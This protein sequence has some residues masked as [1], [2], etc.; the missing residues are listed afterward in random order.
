M[1]KISN[2]TLYPNDVVFTG[3]EILIGT[4]SDGRTATYLLSA[5]QSYFGGSLDAASVKSLYE[6]NS[7]TNAF[8]DAEK[9]KLAGL[10]GTTT[11]D[12][13]V[14]VDANAKFIFGDPDIAELFTDQTDM[15]MNL[16][17]TTGGNFLFQ[18][19]G[20]DIVTISRS[21][22]NISTIGTLS[23]DGNIIQVKGA[24]PRVQYVETDNGD[25]TWFAIIDGGN[26]SIRE[27]SVSSTR[28]RIN[29]TSGAEFFGGGLKVN[30]ATNN[31]FAIWAESNGSNESGIFFEASSNGELIL[32]DATGN[33]DVH[34]KT[35]GTSTFANPVTVTGTMTATTFSGSASSLTGL[36]ISG[37]DA[38]GTPGSTTFL[39]GDG[40]WAV[41]PGTSGG[42]ASTIINSY[43][44]ETPTGTQ[45]GVNT[46]FTLP[47]G[48]YESG[49]LVV[50]VN[51]SPVTVGS[52]LS[53]TTPGSG[54]F[55]LSVA[56]LADDSLYATFN[57]QSTGATPVVIEGVTGTKDG[58]NTSFTVNS[59]EYTAGS[60]IIIMNGQ[61]LQD[62]AGL[63]ENTPGSGTF[64]LD[65]APQSTDVILAIHK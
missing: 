58:S 59:A 50:Y 29:A 22:G 24:S 25:K 40:S 16:V 55:D 64:T 39:R 44:G 63:T 43:T 42:G 15:I 52:G 17:A 61:A 56:P 32:R 65:Y 51:N 34:L 2:T 54:I 10:G 5:L 48:E 53:E 60:L 31:A 45:D 35:S 21:S 26:Y 7:N 36:P 1:G 8:T 3:D 62:G 18:N 19:N 38:T 33:S 11:F 41:P 14:D 57:L 12:S 13:N 20:S 47:S 9:T 28:F 6:S 37:I 23:A 49:S 4:D 30:S 46:T 27:S